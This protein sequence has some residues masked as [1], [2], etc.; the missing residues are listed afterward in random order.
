MCITKYVGLGSLIHLALSLNKLTV[1][2]TDSG[3]SFL[4]LLFLVR[5][6]FSFVT[7]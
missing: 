2:M 7:Y 5:L 3:G 6:R 4:L 1:F